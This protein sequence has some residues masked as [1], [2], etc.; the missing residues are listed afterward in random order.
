MFCLFFGHIHTGMKRN[1]C[2]FFVDTQHLNM[3]NGYKES[4][5]EEKIRLKKTKRATSMDRMFIVICFVAFFVYY[6]L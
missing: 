2:C 1:N 4:V 3:M 6:M 5:N